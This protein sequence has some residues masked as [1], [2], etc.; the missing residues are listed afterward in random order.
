MEQTNVTVTLPVVQW[1]IVLKALGELPFKESADIIN[2]IRTQAEAQ[3]TP[4]PMPVPSPE[5]PEA[6]AEAV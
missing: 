2:T 4:P 1:N 5:T 3:L 6:S